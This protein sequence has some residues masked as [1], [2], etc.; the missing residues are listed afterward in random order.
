MIILKF[1][2]DWLPHLSDWDPDFDPFKYYWAV[3]DGLFRN[4]KDGEADLIALDAPG[5]EFLHR[6][7]L[8]MIKFTDIVNLYDSDLS[9]KN[10]NFHYDKNGKWTY[11]D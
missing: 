2:K 1:N 6:I 9:V 11:K 8:S 7:N 10:P 3:E 4:N 5:G